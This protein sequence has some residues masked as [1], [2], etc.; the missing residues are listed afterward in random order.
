MFFENIGVFDSGIGGIPVMHRLAAEFKRANFIYLG[1][2]GNVPYG[3]RSAEEIFEL[4][5]NGCEVL[6]NGG[7]DII[8]V[9]CNTA[10]VSWRGG[11]EY[12]GVKVF[13]LVPYIGEEFKN[14][15]GVFIATPATVNYCRTNNVF[16]D[17]ADLTLTP[18]PYLAEQIEKK[19]LYGEVLGFDDHLVSTL[20]HFDYVYLGC[21][22]Y[23]YL[24]QAVKSANPKVAILDGIDKMIDN[25]RNFC[26]NTN[27]VT[28]R[29]R[30]IRFIG[31]YAEHNRKISEQIFGNE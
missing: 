7:A 3:R 30:T 20:D 11:D 5:Q 13:R 15:K 16:K 12:D 4:T 21:T 6:K 22:H 31:E 2:N 10:S 14:K 26:N 28:E 1:D 27:C 24:K 23:L 19:V 8:A 9:A 18:M 29:K 25:I 17:C